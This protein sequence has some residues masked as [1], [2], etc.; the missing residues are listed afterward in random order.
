MTVDS[1]A[2]KQDLPG[3]LSTP[4]LAEAVGAVE[5]KGRLHILPIVAIVKEGGT[6]DTRLR[7]GLAW[8]RQ[9]VDAEWNDLVK[10]VSADS[11]AQKEVERQEREEQ[12]RRAAA[13]REA[14]QKER[15]RL[16]A[17]ETAKAS[18][19]LPSDEAKPEARTETPGD[20]PQ[21]SARRLP[22]IGN[23]APERA[24]ALVIEVKDSSPKGVV[25]SGESANPNDSLDLPNAVP[26]P[27]RAPALGQS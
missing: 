12:K 22:P 25:A 24:E 19:L 14:R 5:T 8:L 4:L 23:A 27:A 18:G 11:A 17:E 20:V 10:R 15:E 2:N 1:L 13:A 6:M 7:D 21:V 3:A 26:S 16:A 9:S